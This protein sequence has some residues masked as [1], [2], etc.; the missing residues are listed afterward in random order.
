RVRDQ[1]GLEVH[2][3]AIDLSFGNARYAVT[4][5]VYWAKN[6]ALVL[7]YAVKPELP[8]NPLE[9]TW[10]SQ[11]Y[12]EKPDPA[13]ILPWR[14]DPEKGLGLGEEAQRQRTKDIIFDP[15]DPKVGDTIT[16][17]ARIQNYSLLPTIGAVKVRFYVGD[18][19]AGGTLILSTT[20]AP[21]VFTDTAIPARGSSVVS[22]QWQLPNNISQFSR[23]YAVLD[24]DG[25]M[26]EIHE[27][28]NKGWSVLK[29][30]GGLPT[31]V[32]V[33][34]EMN[35]P[36]AFSLSQ[37]YPNPFWSGATSR[38]AGNPET[39]IAYALPKPAHVRLAIYNVL[40]QEVVRLVDK[41]QSVGR[42][43]VH[44]DGHN[45]ASGLYFY[46][47]EAGEFAQTRRMLLVR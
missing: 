35:I 19:N 37:N 15:A 25:N 30:E 36:N 28:N 20:G 39:Q 46:R 29:V 11:R 3:D 6:S 38:F 44:V 18:P 8:N 17:K 16:I 22:M 34:D 43:H 33:T 23:I 24:P 45:L 41:L 26:S 4:P 1:K 14:Y 13:F 10:W 21:E 42:Y 32:E 9:S 2:L 47:L 7:D 31:D 12:G 40:G 5:Y 27:S